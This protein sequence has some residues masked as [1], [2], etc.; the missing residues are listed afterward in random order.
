MREYAYAAAEIHWLFFEH[1]AVNK[2][3]KKLEGGV[4]LSDGG[5]TRP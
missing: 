4:D 2:R 3:R 1:I 5:S